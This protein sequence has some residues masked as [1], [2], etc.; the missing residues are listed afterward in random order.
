MDT[1]QSDILVVK[2]S[3]E[4]EPFS[5][6]KLRRSL[7]RA[8]V[9]REMIEEIVIH[10]RQEL[11]SGSKTHDIY[12]HAFSLLRRRE[13]PAAARYSLKRAIMELGPTGHPFENLVGEL[14]KLQGFSVEVATIVQ[15]MCVSH[16]VDVVAEKDNHRIM[17]ECKFHNAQGLKSD[18]KVA[19]Y[20]QARFEDICK[21]W[22]KDP[23]SSREF[24]EAWLVTNTELTSDAIAYA[25]CMGMKAIGWNYP[26]QGSL[27]D[28]IEQTG[29]HPLTCLTTLSGSSKR[30]LL[31]KGLVLC[32]DVA[33]NKNVLQSM[34]FNQPK[35]A[36]VEKEITQL[37]GI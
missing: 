32:K 13:R 15:G 18:V 2:A 10:V 19:L 29:L 37:C 27:Q 3:G 35:I 17:V 12:K 1:Q 36:Q 4:V 5:D 28:L 9:S 14:L 33:A 34:G 23:H 7:E 11:V 31:D 16:E 20:V 8:K 26:E 30:V 6:A 21:R 24:H 22:Q 25:S